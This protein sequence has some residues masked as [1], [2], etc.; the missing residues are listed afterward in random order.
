MSTS[1]YIFKILIIPFLLKVCFYKVFYELY[2]Q[3]NPLKFPHY[4]N[5]INFS[6]YSTSIK[7]IALYEPNNLKYLANNSYQNFYY[8][9]NI[10]EK[11]ERENITKIF[12]NNDNFQYLENLIY[13]IEL[14]KSHGIYGFGF[15]YYRYYNSLEKINEQINIIYNNKSI[16]FNYLL[17]LKTENLEN[18][19]IKALTKSEYNDDKSLDFIDK[20]SKYL[21]DDRYIRVKDAPIIGIDNP[22]NITN[23]NEMILFWRK[24]ILKYGIKKIF[25]LGTLNNNNIS[26][27]NKEI[28]VDGYVYL[29][30]YKNI[31]PYEFNSKIIYSYHGLIYDNEFEISNFTIFKSSTLPCQN[32]YNIKNESINIFKD[33]SYYKFYLLNKYIIDF[34][35]NNYEKDKQF[36][37]I[38]SF[39]YLINNELL[40]E[41][42]FS[43][44]NSFSK[45]LFNLSLLESNYDLIN[46][47]KTA[48]IAIQAHVFY[49]DLFEEMLSKINNIP[50]KFDLYLTTTS[51]MDKTNIEQYLKLNNKAE[52]YE[53]L[54]VKNR[55]RDV[56][57]FIFQ[58]NKV[59]KKYKYICHIHSKKTLF[60]SLS[61]LW[62]NYLYDN[63][64]GSKEIINDI[65]YKF[66]TNP[67]LGIVS[68]EN[69]FPIIG[70][71][72]SLLNTTLYFMNYILNDNY[73]TFKINKAP[74]YPA[75]NMFWARVSSIYQIFEKLKYINDNCPEEK[76]VLFDTILH[77]IERIWIV[78][79]QMNGYN[80]TTNFRKF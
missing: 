71:T 8:E 45:A 4:E 76:G 39:N 43:T 80:Y 44:I 69:Y 2:H 19:D 68:P 28:L 9:K 73:P 1:T 7:A 22:E 50:V 15:Y 56:L 24:K 34:T 55:G 29:P 46:L 37:F 14:A 20:I 53:I 63:I 66:E 38:N 64:L 70:H 6:E 54:V 17:I 21:L 41:E 51:E 13:Q 11:K 78:F 57:P 61:K 16:D 30:T 60:P 52:K 40:D 12:K 25:I 35:L 79:A 49:I 10:M 18:N 74:E 42:G 3:Y 26:Y 77:A 48:I 27:I 75:G 59:Y 33:Y 23:S 58:M 32:E 65:L 67:K 47:E 62:R 36:I 72:Y 31:E 5:N